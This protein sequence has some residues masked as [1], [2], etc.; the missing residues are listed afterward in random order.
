MKKF[1]LITLAMAFIATVTS[2]QIQK[3]YTRLTI[4]IID[5]LGNKVEGA[6]VKIYKTKEDYDKLE[7]EVAAETSDSKGRVY[8]RELEPIAYYVLAEKDDM[9]NVTLGEKTSVLEENKNNK[10]NIVIT[11]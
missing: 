9:N 1:V 10:A 2:F 6:S 3:S 7:N 8:F 11:Q 4:T 5:E